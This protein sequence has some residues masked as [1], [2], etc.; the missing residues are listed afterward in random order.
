MSLEE[1]RTRPSFMLP[2]GSTQQDA[3][4]WVG[5]LVSLQKVVQ[6]DYSSALPG[7]MLNIRSEK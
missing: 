1:R 3:F 6:M 2:C 4:L 5:L 7:K